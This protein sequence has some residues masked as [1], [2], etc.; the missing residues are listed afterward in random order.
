MHRKTIGF[1]IA[2]VALVVGCKSLPTLQEQFNTSCAIVNADLKTL[3]TAP[4]LTVEQQTTIMQKVL[5]A[6]QTICTAGAGLSVANLRTFH[7]SLLPVAVGIVQATPS[8]PDQTL[9]LL[10]LNTFGPLVQQMIDTIISGVAPA[11]AP[12][13]ASAPL[14][15]SALVAS[16]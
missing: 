10:A 13:A 12:A 9:V 3:G 7:D 4:Q 1:A 6:N 11:S 8:L 16:K 15:A 2:A 5:P 14:A